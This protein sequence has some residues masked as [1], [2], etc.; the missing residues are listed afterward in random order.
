MSTEAV[1]A[2]TGRD[3]LLLA[4]ECIFNTPEAQHFWP[5]A[6]RMYL[7][8]ALLVDARW[9]IDGR[10]E[11]T[12]PTSSVYRGII[13]RLTDLVH[14]LDDEIDDEYTKDAKCIQRATEKAL[15]VW[16]TL[17]QHIL[18]TEQNESPDEH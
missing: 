13:K 2:S 5:P 6:L 14:I 7:R 9:F 10:D 17:S 18:W 11:Y 1:L 15:S 16:L 12:K 3:T 8:D 4:L